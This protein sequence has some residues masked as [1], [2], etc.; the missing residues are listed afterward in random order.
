MNVELVQ[1]QLL[2]DRQSEVEEENLGGG[3]RIKTL[4]SVRKD[5]LVTQ[6]LMKY[7]EILENMNLLT[8]LWQC[9]VRAVVLENFV[10]ASSNVRVQTVKHLALME[11]VLIVALISHVLV[12]MIHKLLLQLVILH[13]KVLLRSFLM[14]QEIVNIDVTGHEMGL[15]LIKQ[16]QS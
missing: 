4:V 14:T 5:T 8:V 11:M 9:V 2:Q 13:V 3:K 1:Q 16:K 6:I 15:L 12:V 10:I 7:L